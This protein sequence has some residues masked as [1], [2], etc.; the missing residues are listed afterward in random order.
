M[1]KTGRGAK[2]TAH[3]SAGVMETPQDFLLALRKDIAYRGA[4]VGGFSG[5]RE[6]ARISKHRVE[7]GAAIG[8]FALVLSQAG[9][10]KAVQAQNLKARSRGGRRALYVAPG[11]TPWIC[12]QW[13]TFLFLF[14]TSR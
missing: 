1:A 4:A 2:G 5:L 10:S 6:V 11:I 7:L 14:V 8:H 12:M 3:W 9:A 13:A